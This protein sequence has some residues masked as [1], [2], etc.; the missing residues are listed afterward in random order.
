VTVVA[1]V[2]NNAAT[3]PDLCRRLRESVPACE[4]VLVDDASTDESRAVMRGL[5]V[6]TVALPARLGQSEAIRQGLA[7]ASGR[8]CC[9]LDAD[10]QDPPEALPLML[11]RL[12]RGDADV[13]F[14]TRDGR[15]RLT[16]RLFR[17]AMRLLYPTLTSRACLCFAAGDAAA[18]DIVHRARPGDYLVAIIG[19]LALRTTQVAVVRKPRPGGG[20]GY[21]GLRRARHGIATFISAVRLR[22]T[23]MPSRP[24]VTS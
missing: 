14:S 4:I 23:A 8:S 22:W 7:R 9:V 5:D 19:V 13:V 3:L 6:T 21:A 2:H 12:R 15:R 18:A 24:R 16:S 20:S 17:R 11:A 1:A 10:L